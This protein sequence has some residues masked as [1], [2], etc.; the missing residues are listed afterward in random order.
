MQTISNSS[1]ISNQ[2]FLVGIQRTISAEAIASIRLAIRLEYIIAERIPL[3][4][5]GNVFV[6]SCPWHQSR[7]RRSFV[8]YPEKQTWRCWGCAVGG[9]VFSFFMRF[10]GISFP[11]AVKLVANITGVTVDGSPLSERLSARTELGQVEKQIA[12]I[13]DAE[14]MRAARELDRVNR[15]QVR[16]GLRLA[17]LLNGSISRFAGEIEFCWS[18][19]QY[20]RALLPRLDAEFVLLGFGK[21]SDRE[22]FV[23]A[24]ANE[25]RQIIDEILYEGYVLDDRNYRREV[26]LQ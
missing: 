24:D 20:A 5:S 22:R 14:F 26:P 11:T 7:S 10:D 18:A 6:G 12:K 2:D 3:R 9:D 1:D 15:M 21:S 13:L 19:L 25:Q 23:L 8:V 4:R 17:E 16:A